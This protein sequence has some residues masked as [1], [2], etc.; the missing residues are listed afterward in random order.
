MTTKTVT[1]RGLWQRL[2][3]AERS[4]ESRSAPQ[5]WIDRLIALILYSGVRSFPHI[6]FELSTME[7]SSTSGR[8]HAPFLP[9]RSQSFRRSI[10]P[11]AVQQ[12]HQRLQQRQQNLSIGIAGVLFAGPAWAGD[13]VQEIQQRASE[14]PNLPSAAEVSFGHTY[15]LSLCQHSAYIPFLLNDS[16]RGLVSWSVWCFVV[17]WGLQLSGMKSFSHCA[18]GVSLWHEQ[19]CEMCVIL[20]SLHSMTL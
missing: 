15:A 10:V 5:E 7:V 4:R 19:R 9:A 2:Q 8:I 12:R 13:A 3:N 16:S 11:H 18:S 1:N 6:N 17:G 14:L 20:L